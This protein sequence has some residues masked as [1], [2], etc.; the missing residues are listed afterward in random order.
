MDN[1][2][3]RLK[4]IP[5]TV[6]NKFVDVEVFYDLG[7]MNAF[8]YK[9]EARGYYLAVQPLELDGKVIKFMLFSGTKMLLEASPRFSPKKL[10]EV[11][12]KALQHPDYRELL[13][14]VLE[15]GNISIAETAL[16]G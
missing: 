15:K 3:V 13:K 2:K 11:A 9:N 14:S 4:R 5:T 1:R 10:A 6:E 8:T 16:L 12:A 7:G